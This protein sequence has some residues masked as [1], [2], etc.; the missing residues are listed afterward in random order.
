[1]T[2]T[3]DPSAT[4]I[5]TQA[6]EQG[7]GKFERRVE[8]TPGHCWL[9]ENPNKNYG[10][11]ACRVIFY[12]I[13]A[14][15]AVQWMIGTDWY[16]K[17]ARDHLSKFAYRNEVQPQ[18]WDIGYHAR[19]PQYEGQ[20]CLTNDCHLLGGKCFYD[21]SSLSAEEWVEGFLNGGTEWLWP[22]L[23]EYYRS[24][25]EGGKYPDV[26]PIIKPNPAISKALARCPS[27]E[28]QRGTEG[29]R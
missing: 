29:S 18:A 6:V 5:S 4:S 10:V 13:G 24:V 12:V 20:T 3:S 8:V 11:A 15:G 28:E 16:P 21:G 7:A 14:K 22:R 1:V 17:A 2:T 19:E 27:T 26:S 25:F 9:H 23:E